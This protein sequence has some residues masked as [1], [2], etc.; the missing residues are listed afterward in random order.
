MKTLTRKQLESRK[1]KAVR[2]TRD[3]LDDPERAAEIEDEP[4][5]DYAARRHFK[6][7]NRE[8]AKPMALR[9]RH[10]LVEI[11][12]RV[13]AHEREAGLER[14]KKRRRDVGSS[15]AKLRTQKAWMR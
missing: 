2:F 7:G 5:E 1:S 9:T 13:S 4:L 3:V 14:S 8:G 11:P 10:A 6:I 15:L 12:S